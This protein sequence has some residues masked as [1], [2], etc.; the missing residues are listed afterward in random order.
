MKELLAT[1]PVLWER[2]QAADKPIV[3]YGMGDGADKILNYCETLG[4]PVQGIFASDEFVR[5]HLFRGYVV[6][7]YASI[8]KRL[9]D[10][11]VLVAFGTQNPEVMEQILRL[12]EEQELYAPDVPVAGEEYFTKDFFVEHLEEF[13]KV[14]SLLADTLS[15]KTF[16]HCIRF[17]LSGKLSYLEEI[18]VSPT[19]IFETI[20]PLGDQEFFVDAGAYNGDTVLEFIN[21]V[22]NK[23]QGILAIEPS[24]RNY[25]RLLKNTEGLPN[26]F[27]FQGAA[28]DSKDI[29]YFKDGRGRG[30]TLTAGEPNTQVNTIDALLGE[31]PG[32]TASYINY[33]V[34]G[35]EQQALAGSVNTIRAH[36]P[37]LWISAYHRSRDLFALPLQVLEILPDYQLYYRH[38]PYIPAWDIQLL[39]LPKKEVLSHE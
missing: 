34:E 5:G 33:D 39:A 13:E 25:K 2:L 19:E 27:T 23:Y 21:L 3:L 35:A 38:N 24:K 18:S 1:T 9:G 14:N 6:E 37:K 36:K 32:A 10:M 4:I 11:I 8:K 26:F 30:S 22:G 16:Q 28:W 17:K 20:F 15:Q 7:K 29:L 31:I 12:G